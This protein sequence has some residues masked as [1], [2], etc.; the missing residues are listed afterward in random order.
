MLAA[1]QASRAFRSAFSLSLCA[2]TLATQ[3]NLPATHIAPPPPFLSDD[4][5]AGHGGPLR[6]HLNI[7]VDP[8]HGLWAFFRKKEVDGKMT[9]LTV[10]SQDPVSERS[11]RSWTAAEL[12]RKSFKD[13]HTLWYVLLRE[14]N[15]LATQRAEARRLGAASE[16]LSLRKKTFRCRKSMARIKYVINERRLAYEGA[17]NIFAEKRENELA[18]RRAQRQARRQ[19]ADAKSAVE[20]K[21]LETESRRV[22]AGRGSGEA[23]RGR[24]I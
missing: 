5:E 1:L 24:S 18:A 11:G 14:R 10:E 6:P 4:P 15:L 17:M 7:P 8:N 2:R 12:R 23:G 22:K 13:L 9:Y 20:A 19:E 21:A 16:A 3:T